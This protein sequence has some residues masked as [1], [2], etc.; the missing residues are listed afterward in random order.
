[1]PWLAAG[2]NFHIFSDYD[3]IPVATTSQDPLTQD[4]SLGTFKDFQIPDFEGKLRYA[5]QKEIRPLLASSSKDVFETA[6]TAIQKMV[7]G[8]LRES[9]SQGHHRMPV[10]PVLQQ[11]GHTS[12]DTSAFGPMDYSMG[13][14]AETLSYLPTGNATQQFQYE[15]FGSY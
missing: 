3:Y 4:W 14:Q 13:T 2:A 7:L 1:L 11:G 9:Q 8:A 10:K 15:A 5:I 6:V 12:F